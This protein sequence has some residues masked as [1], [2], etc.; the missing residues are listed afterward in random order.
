MPP[1]PSQRS[2]FN[3][4][5]RARPQ[6]QYHPHPHFQPPV[7]A[8]PTDFTA[9]LNRFVTALSLPPEHP[10]LQANPCRAPLWAD[11]LRDQ[12][13]RGILQVSRLQRTGGGAL[14]RRAALWAQG[15]FKAQGTGSPCS[16][17]GVLC[18]KSTALRPSAPRLSSRN[19][20]CFTKDS[21][22]GPPTANRQPPT[23]TNRQP[24]VQYCFYGFVPCPCHGHEAESV[25]V[26]VRFCWRY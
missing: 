7:T 23:A 17:G 9:R 8:H 1:T 6:P 25:P 18:A 19:S 26:K 22:Q 4:T 21:P 11:I 13:G 14:R 5:G 10:P 2:A 3:S 16:A 20:I 12:G 24:I 15:V